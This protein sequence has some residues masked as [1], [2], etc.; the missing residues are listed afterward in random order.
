MQGLYFALGVAAVALVIRWYIISERKGEEAPGI[1]AM[2]QQ[3]EVPVKDKRKRAKFRL[4][5]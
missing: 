1:F 2:R 4:R 3:A 5:S